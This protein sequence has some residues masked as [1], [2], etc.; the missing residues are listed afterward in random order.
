MFYQPSGAGIPAP[1]RLA[2]A[3][4]VLLV[5]AAFTLPAA[6]T[7]TVAG[8]TA[9]SFAV[10]STGAAT[11]TIPI[12]A[13]PGPNGMQPHIALTYNSQQGNGIVGVGWYVSGLSSIYRCNL[14]YAQDAAPA[15][16]G[17]VTSDGYC[18]DGQRLRLT[19]GTYG[20]AGSTYQT[21]V[22]NFINVA[23]Y[24]T[25]GNGPAYWIAKDRNG[26]SYTYGNGGNSQ[27][28]ATGSTTAAAWMLNEVSDPPGNTM[29]ISYNTATGSA[30]PATIS[31]TPSSHGSSTYNYTMNFAYGANVPQSSLYAY[32]AGTAVTN[33]NLL[34]SITIE[35]SGTTVKKYVLTYQA[36]PTTARDELK[37]VQE[38]SDSGGTNCLLPTVITYQNGSS[39]VSTTAK[40]LSG[41]TYSEYD[42]DGN[43][44]T[45]LLYA[46]GG[47]YYVAF[48]SA[49][50]YGTPVSTGITTAS[51]SQILIGDLL[52][53]GTD[54]IL[55]ASGGTWYYYA[56]NG[57]SFVKTSTGLAYD[58]TA[59]QYL[60][61]D[62]NGN[63]LP[64]L[65]AAYF[66]QQSNGTGILSTFTIDTHLNTGAGSTV[67][68]G[69]AIQSYQMTS[70]V[71]DAV[72]QLVSD[73]DNAGGT[74]LSMGGLR[75]FDFNGD[76]RD[77]LAMQTV[78]QNSP[79]CGGGTQVVVSSSS[80]Q[81]QPQTGC[82][83][84]V[85]TYQL[86][87]GGSTS[88]PT[89][90]AYQIYS[91]TGTTL[92][93]V[94]FLDFNSDACTDYLV[95][96][97]LYVAG[98]NGSAPSTLSLGTANVIGAMDWDGDGR[99]DILVQNG[100]TIGVYLSTGN[101]FSSLVST[102]IPYSSSNYYYTFKPSG[103]GQDALG[104]TT[105]S[106]A[107]Y[108]YPHNGLGTPPDLVTSI[109]DGYGNSASPIYV[110]LVEN[111]YVENGYG[112]PTY[113]DS[114]WIGPM[115]AVS[116]VTF[117]DPSS[118]SGGTYN[119]TFGYYGAWTN[120]QGR[121]W[122]SFYSVRTYDSRNGLYQYNYFE[123]SFP[124]TGMQFESLITNGT[125]YPT[126]TV[127][128]LASLVTLSSTQYQQRYF[129][130]FSNSTNYKKE[131]GGT[132]NGDLITTTSTNYTL[133]NYAN[134]TSITKT[135][136][137]N[138][139]GSPYNGAT[140]TTTTT[141][142]TDVDTTHWC[143]G[144]FTETQVA[145]SSSLTGSGSVTRTKTFTPDTTNCRYTQTVTEPSSSQFK[146]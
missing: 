104:Y 49:T 23:A 36:S 140:W 70:Y 87:A 119:Q 26:Q 57:S 88:S 60:L 139:P 45:D 40:S 135:I 85:K 106:G 52:G 95:G 62:V 32:T 2:V 94:A 82:T 145:Y 86:L 113:P 22:A 129:A 107:A 118:S 66:S 19:G 132:E 10:S 72:P 110:S 100:S 33:T 59:V 69:S 90:T 138:D 122:E 89:F 17:L 101:G 133:D 27:V 97:T 43:G 3:T 126:Q 76:G 102:S 141:N 29:T 93:S 128:T 8:R 1:T 77:D 21:E 50:G 103:Y 9:G 131:V 6:G 38:C 48:G 67:S 47:T 108:Y 142:T 91:S 41:G 13:P 54:I 125:F 81:V 144:L 65:I 15:P 73:T 134:P 146:V 74:V 5:G 34:S 137:D 61:A 80:Q 18:M 53:K 84:Y 71:L 20:T 143:L 46:S 83:Y 56:W 30:V 121:G 130:Y 68:F 25:A 16:I 64:A 105:S 120:V 111:N 28:L 35:Y 92:L 63:G 7:T 44:F 42:F 55:V 116:Q 4:L 136:T 31:W 37:Q 39:G 109:T 51:I 99:T 75:R 96:D 11:Y 58:S 24:G 114:A 115:Y 98:C 127:N 79:G 124:Y 14:T 112:T 117:S 12:W 78:T 123:R